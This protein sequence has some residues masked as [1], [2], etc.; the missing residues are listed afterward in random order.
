MGSN[1]IS[2]V[3]RD[4]KRSEVYRIHFHLTSRAEDFTSRKRSGVTPDYLQC[5]INP[6]SCNMGLDKR[7]QESQ[8]TTRDKT[9]K[10]KSSGAG[11]KQKYLKHK[12]GQL[13]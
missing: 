3:T 11:S 10:G 13:H 4:E 9:T 12:K 1:L 5:V 6:V 7:Y 2:A 8:L